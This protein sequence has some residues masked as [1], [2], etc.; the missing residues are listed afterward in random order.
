MR[1][2][3]S[4][5]LLLNKYASVIIINSSN[6]YYILLNIQLAR[7]G[8]TLKTSSSHH[9]RLIKLWRFFNVLTQYTRVSSVPKTCSTRNFSGR[10]FTPITLK[11]WKSRI[12]KI[13]RVGVVLLGKFIQLSQLAHKD[14]ESSDRVTGISY[15]DLQTKSRHH[16]L[17]SIHIYI[18]GY[19]YHVYV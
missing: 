16:R 6:P 15:Y 9:S 3:D 13:I 1:V 4:S 5:Y 18:L 14:W 7:T 11:N 12:L 8:H 10:V 19:V 17:T 2:H